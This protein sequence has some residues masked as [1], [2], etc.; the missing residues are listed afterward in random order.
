MKR[1]MKKCRL[2]SVVL[3][4]MCLLLT[5]SAVSTASILYEDADYTGETLTH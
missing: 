2:F 1:N 3:L 4:L 5:A